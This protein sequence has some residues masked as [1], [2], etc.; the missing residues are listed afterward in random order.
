MKNTFPSWKYNFF[1]S[2]LQ[3]RG[4]SACP[5]SPTVLHCKQLSKSRGITFHIKPNNNMNIFYW[6]TMRTMR[7]SRHHRQNSI[8]LNPGARC[9]ELL[10]D[11]WMKLVVIWFTGVACFKGQ[12]GRYI[13]NRYIV[14]STCQHELF[15]LYIKVMVSH[16]SVYYA[17][18]AHLSCHFSM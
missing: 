15:S 18:D 13:W 4:F 6:I 2:V 14:H 12:S 17:S 8:S 5:V 7:P 10:V 11:L 9:I 16:I 1:L 3:T